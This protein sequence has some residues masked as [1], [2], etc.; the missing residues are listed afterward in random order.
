MHERENGRYAIN[1]VPATIRNF[2]RNHGLPP[3]ATQ[4]GRICFEK[5]DVKRGKEPATFI[6]PGHPLLDAV[7]GLL[8]EKHRDVLKHGAVLVD[9]T[10]PGR[11]P[12]MLFYME[13]SIRDAHADVTRSGERRIV[14]REVHFV[15]VS[16][17]GEARVG[18][19]APYLDYRAATAAER[20]QLVA[21][22]PALFSEAEFGVAQERIAT[23]H[24]I[25]QLVPR[26]LDDVRQKRL[27]LIVKTEAAVNER[28]TREI[29]YWDMRANEL[30]EHERAGKSN[31]RLNW[32]KAKQRADDLAARLDRRIVELQQERDIVAEPPIITGGT[33]IV[34]IGLLL[35]SRTPVDILDTRITEQI[36][37]HAV[38]EI[39]RRMG[40]DPRDVSADK[41]GYDIESRDPAAGRLRF[42]EVKGRRAG[43]ET[44]T[45]TRNEIL[46]ALNVPDEFVL[47]LVEVEEAKA[48]STCYVQHPFS[49][50]PDTDVASVNYNWRELWER[51]EMSDRL[52]P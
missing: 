13:Q 22:R 7:I 25:N 33:L 3:V 15:E 17:S 30:R 45:V 27:E 35:G 24:A 6:C 14:S 41:L 5:A 16:P 38:M 19:G 32:Q 20:D 31:A 28:L 44:V 49:K 39:E 23:A 36:A 26:H 43:A 10:D 18:G 12:R 8:M 50:E 42:I 29:N 40:H 52:N 2:A 11:E 51:G 1:N 48:A 4:Y 9:E 47:A 37:M 21:L 46:H 34:P